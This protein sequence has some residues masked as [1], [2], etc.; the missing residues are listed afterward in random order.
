MNM[1]SRF[2]LPDHEPYSGSIDCQQTCEDWLRVMEEARVV[3]FKLTQLMEQAK[4]LEGMCSD[5]RI[6]CEPNMADTI[7]AAISDMNLDG[8]I[9]R[10]DGET[11][12]YLEGV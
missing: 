1:L 11:A 7:E 12:K 3:R 10:I 5:N 2:P 8:L 9:S 4:N 6:P